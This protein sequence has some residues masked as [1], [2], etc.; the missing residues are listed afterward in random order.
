M[1][2]IFD[3]YRAKIF[4]YITG[5]NVPPS[6]REDVFSEILL[7]AQQQAKRYDSAKAGV[8]TWVYM[9]TRS[10]VADYYRKRKQEYPLSEVLTCVDSVEDYIDYE[11][12][13]RELAKQLTKLPEME[14]RIVILRLYKD[15]SHAE[16][17]RV[18][19]ISE[20]NS[21][22]IYSRAVGRLRKRMDG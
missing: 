6:E 19:G 9:I 15:M 21:R 3:E 10:V 17:A 7:K 22:T 18:L 13:L 5:K 20:T 12:D 14:R 11:E 1:E 16:I 4:G 2:Q 8:S